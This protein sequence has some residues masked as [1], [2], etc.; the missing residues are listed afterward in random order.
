MS[1]TRQQYTLLG[2]FALFF[3]PLIM[4]ILMRSSYWDYRPAHMKNRGEMVQPPYPLDISEEFKGEWLLMYV[5]PA[6]CSNACL[7]QI[8]A[9]RQ[10]YKASGRQQEHLQ[11]VVLN[12]GSPNPELAKSVEAIFSD[13]SY[14]DS[15]PEGVLTS[16]QTINANL[17]TSPAKSID[18][19]TYILD[20][21]Q[22]VILAYKT[23]TNPTDINKDLKQLLKWSKADNVQ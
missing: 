5:T 2:L 11:V 16:L 14:I 17:P 19:Q 12:S 13:I 10:I 18:R 4:V 9:L 8:T 15:V 7:N 20:P 22:N 21:M 3:L 1:L 6:D 23:D